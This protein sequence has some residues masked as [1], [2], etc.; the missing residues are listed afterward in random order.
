MLQLAAQSPSNTGTHQGAAE[1]CASVRA[2]SSWVL[3]CSFSNR[4]TGPGGLESPH[5]GRDGR[6]SVTSLLLTWGQRQM[7]A[8]VLLVS[9]P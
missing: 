8:R 6:E 9:D 5:Q 4:P 7:N 3:Q 1:A 2:I